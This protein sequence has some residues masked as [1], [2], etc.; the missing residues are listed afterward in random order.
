MLG[1]YC[2]CVQVVVGVGGTRMMVVVRVTNF[3][4]TT[5]GVTCETCDTF[6][7]SRAHSA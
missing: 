2:C 4:W 6:R 3:D 5:E 1:V 7:K